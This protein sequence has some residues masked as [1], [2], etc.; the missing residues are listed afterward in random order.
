MTLVRG[1]ATPDREKG[2]DDVCWADTNLTGPKNKENTHDQF[3][4]YK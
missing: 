4:C 3:N 1:E 2:G